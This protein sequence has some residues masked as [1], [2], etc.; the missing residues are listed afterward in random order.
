MGHCHVLLCLYTYF[1]GKCGSFFSFSINN[2]HPPL[3]SSLFNG[4]SNCLGRQLI[5]LQYSKTNPENWQFHSFT[6]TSVPF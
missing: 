1:L 6:I 3:L 4:N 2:H 5:D